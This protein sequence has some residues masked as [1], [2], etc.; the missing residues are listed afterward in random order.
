MKQYTYIIFS[1]GSKVQK[2]VQEKKLGKKLLK[3][4]SAF[5]FH[6]F[7]NYKFTPI[8]K[9]ISVVCL[10]KMQDYPNNSN[11]CTVKVI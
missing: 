5:D 1:L 2:E 6:F 11:I 8:L 7:M 3:V 10:L 9:T 4:E